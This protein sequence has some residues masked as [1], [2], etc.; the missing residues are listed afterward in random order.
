MSNII[1]NHGNFNLFAI[2]VDMT[3]S[4]AG[5]ESLYLKFQSLIQRGPSRILFTYFFVPVADTGN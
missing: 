5:L 2:N 3:G 1:E 4:V